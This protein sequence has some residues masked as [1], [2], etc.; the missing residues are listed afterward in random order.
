MA[1]S[2]V[3]REKDALG[4]LLRSV[5]TACR[6]ALRPPA[7]VLR[8]LLTPPPTPTVFSWHKIEEGP[9]TGAQLLLPEGA[10]ITDAITA[11]RYEREVIRFVEKL[12]TEG[13]DCWDVGGHYGY[14][15]AAMAKIVGSSGHVHTFEPIPEH[16]DRIAQAAEKSGLDGVTLHRQ[17]VAGEVGQMT[18]CFSPADAGDDSMAYLD[19]YGGVDTPTAQEHYQH[20]QRTTVSTVTLD[21]LLGQLAPPSLIKIDAEGAEVAIVG[22]AE[23]LLL[24]FKP[25]LL[26]ECH[27]IYEALRCAETLQSFQYRAMLLT[28]QK[29]TMPIL[30]VH[31]D[32]DEA[33]QLVRSVLGSEPVVLFDRAVTQS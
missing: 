13:D 8:Q 19:A 16:A 4:K 32:D 7:R 20:F 23:N 2:P 30:W 9:A 10:E 17:A 27:G 25:R 33:Q 14:F 15:T 26:I 28:N 31:R 1:R 5:Q 24:Q 18:L 21:S 22:A 29:I 3:D 12:V 6:A 11:G